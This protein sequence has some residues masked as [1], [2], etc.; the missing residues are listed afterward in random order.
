MN[1]LAHAYLSFN[2]P[3]I[4]VGN[5]ISD[6]VKGKKQYDYP[7]RIRDGIILHRAIDGFT[8]SHPATTRAKKVFKEHY[9][10]Y[11]AVFTDVVYDHFL[12]TDKNIFTVSTLQYF[13]ESVYKTL[14]YH[15]KYLP[16]T[17]ARMFPYMK[18]QDWLF[19]YSTLDG[20]Q[21]SFNGIARRARYFDSSEVAFKLFL[22]EYEELK[23]CYHSFIADVTAF[24]RN[25]VPDLL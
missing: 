13:S 25:A 4:L 1:F 21:H 14:T 15:E 8:D 12:A 19:N 7:A 11:S 9:R 23:Q 17:F 3:E 6:F 20:I 5:M 22:T 16:Q 10:L 24:A 2:D 18:S